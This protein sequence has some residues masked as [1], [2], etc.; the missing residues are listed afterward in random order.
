MLEKIYNITLKL[1]ER[2]VY[3]FIIY[4]RKNNDFFIFEI[5]FFF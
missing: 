4:I 2:I 5:T 3:N 1:F